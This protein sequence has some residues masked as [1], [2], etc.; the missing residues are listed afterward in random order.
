MRSDYMYYFS[1]SM[2]INHMPKYIEVWHPCNHIHDN[3]V[4]FITHNDDN[5]KLIVDVVRLSKDGF[6]CDFEKMY[7]TF[8]GAK[9]GLYAIYREWN[10]KHRPKLIGT[11]DKL[12]YSDYLYS[13]IMTS[14][15]ILYL[16]NVNNMDK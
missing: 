10:Y 16:E 6:S 12:T 14:A 5:E 3:R 2:S 4:A 9:Y 15:K 7:D 13:Y 11:I 8:R 1:H